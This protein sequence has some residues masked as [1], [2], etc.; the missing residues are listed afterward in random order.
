MVRFSIMTDFEKWD[1]F[2]ADAAEK[3]VERKVGDDAS[4]G[5]VSLSFPPLSF[6]VSSLLL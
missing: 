3:E 1:R 2:D 5:K 4:S 6:L